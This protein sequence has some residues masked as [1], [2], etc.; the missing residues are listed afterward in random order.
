MLNLKKKKKALPTLKLLFKMASN[1]IY[2]PKKLLYF[3][4]M[5]PYVQRLRNLLVTVDKHEDF[6]I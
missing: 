4:F 6:L 5:L 3:L 2:I 1:K